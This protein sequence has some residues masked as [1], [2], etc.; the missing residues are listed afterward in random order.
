MLD[1]NINTIGGKSKRSPT[2]LPS[3][4]RTSPCA[5][6]FSIMGASFPDVGLLSL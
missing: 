5:G 1:F 3:G 6:I 2:L 4:K